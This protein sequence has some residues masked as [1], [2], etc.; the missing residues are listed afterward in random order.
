MKTTHRS[1]FRLAHGFAL[2]T[3][4]LLA[5]CTTPSGPGDNTINEIHKITTEIK[6]SVEGVKAAQGDLIQK[7]A[8]LETQTKKTLQLAADHVGNA[9]Y[10]NLKNTSPNSYT[11]LTS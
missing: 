9:N 5:A 7:Q 3:T 8:S 2:A 1:P 11:Q 10:A 6:T 4:L